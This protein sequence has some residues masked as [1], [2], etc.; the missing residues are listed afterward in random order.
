MP[1]PT[2]PDLL[3]G[4]LAA[5]EGLAQD[6][7]RMTDRYRNKH[8]VKKLNLK[9]SFGKWYLGL[10]CMVVNLVRRISTLSQSKRTANVFR[11]RRY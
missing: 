4:T 2:I 5:N 9:D 3:M 11:P 1:L 6:A 10:S 7:V 8:L